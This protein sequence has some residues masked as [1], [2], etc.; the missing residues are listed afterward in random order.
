MLKAAVIFCSVWCGI[1][2]SVP[3]AADPALTFM[4]IYPGSPPFLYRKDLQGEYRGVMADFLQ[5]LT[6]NTGLEISYV[7]TNRQRGEDALYKGSLDLALFSPVWL[8][9]PTKLLIS[10]PFLKHRSFL[11]SLNPF[12]AHFSVEDLPHGS[13][14]CTKRVY[15]YP[16]LGPHFISGKLMRIDS[17]SQSTMLKMLSKKRC[18]MAIMSEFN[19]MA[20]SNVPKLDLP[21]LYRSEQVISEVVMSIMLRRG[22]TREQALI[23]SYIEKFKASGELAKSLNYHTKLAFQ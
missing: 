3:V 16:V 6:Q 4:V 21:P 13:S 20:L 19:V 2:F 18:D 10:T 14:I 11:Y 17:S 12:P 7:E 1:F 9:Q 15:S 23:N 22:L 8:R 5:G